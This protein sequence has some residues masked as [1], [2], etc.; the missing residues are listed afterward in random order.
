MAGHLEEG[1][2]LARITS[3]PR[4][5]KFLAKVPRGSNLKHSHDLT[6][7]SQNLALTFLGQ[8]V[9]LTVFYM[10]FPLG[11]GSR[12]TSKS[13]SVSGASPAGRVVGTF[14]PSAKGEHLMLY[15]E[16]QGRNL[17][18]T[19]LYEPCSLDSRLRVI[20]KSLV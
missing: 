1:L 20:S 12:V 10:P 4:R 18:L 3:R 16:S 2:P 15:P 6:L 9:A 8:K 19:V 17:A 5:R 7:K 13:F 14:S 11:S